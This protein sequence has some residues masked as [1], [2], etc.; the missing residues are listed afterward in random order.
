MLHSEAHQRNPEPAAETSEDGLP[1]GLYELDDVRVQ[2]DGGH[3]HDDEELAQ[4]FQRSGY[5]C[6]ELEHGRDYGCEHKE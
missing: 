1:A 3:C 6:G 5:S 2:A 4:L